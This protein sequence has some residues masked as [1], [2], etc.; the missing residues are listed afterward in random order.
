VVY[1]FVGQTICVDKCCKFFRRYP[2]F[3]KR[4]NFFA[5]DEEVTQGVSHPS[6]KAILLCEKTVIEAGTG[7]ITLINIVN[8]FMV[9][10]FP[11][12]TERIDAFFQIT[13]AEGK[14]E[15]IV[16]IRDLRE[17]RVLA[18]AIGSEVEIPDRGMACNVVIPVPP[19]RIEHDGLYDF[20]ILANGQ[21]IDRQPFA[22]TAI[23]DED[24]E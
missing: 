23:E 8:R 14:Y 5:D 22:V 9:E 3:L 10:S 12:D 1:A 21:E 11:G 7:K 19:L 2:V 18:R 15:I 13:D 17:D 16:E 20:V 6:C 4:P 24:D